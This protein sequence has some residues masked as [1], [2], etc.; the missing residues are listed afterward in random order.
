[1]AQLTF[2]INNGDLPRTVYMPTDNPTVN[3]LVLSIGC[4]A[5]LVLTAG[6]PVDEGSAPSAAGT[7]FYLHLGSLGLSAAE[8][9]SL[10]LSIPG[11]ETALYPDSQVICLAPSVNMTI[12]VGTTVTMR[13]GNFTAASAPSGPA[14][15]VYMKF[16]RASPVSRGALPYTFNDT[17]SIQ[18]PLS[19][20]E[21]FHGV[22]AVSVSNATVVQ[23]I[24]Q[25]PTVAN[26][27]NLIFSPG[28]NPKAVTAGKNTVF[29]VNFV[30]ADD[31]YGYGALTTAAAAFGIKVRGHSGAS[32]WTITDPPKGSANPGWMLQPREGDLILGTGSTVEFSVA[33]IVSSFQPDA[34]LMVVSYSG[35]PGYQDGA[36]WIVLTKER[37]VAVTSLVATPNPAVLEGG[38]ATVNLSWTATPGARLTLMP[39]AVDVTGQSK[40]QALIRQATQFTLSAQGTGTINYAS[41][42]VQVD[43]FARVNAIAATPQ[44]IYHKDFPHDVLIDWAVDT[45]DAVILSNSVNQS[46]QLF[47]SDGT[48]SVTVLAPQMFTIEPKDQSAGLLIRRNEIVS[49]FQLNRKSLTLS[50]VAVDAALSPTA[51]ICIVAQ[52]G[53]SQLLVLDT[54]TNTPYG[55]TVRAGNTPVAVAFSNDGKQLFVANAGDSTLSVFAVS[56]DTASSAYQFSSTAVVALSGVPAAIKVASDGSA[57]FVTSNAAGGAT[58]VLDVV[59]ANGRGPYVVQNSVRFRNTVG[60]LAA[61]PSGAQIFVVST[62]GSA[63]YVVGYDSISKRYSLVRTIGGF[64]S[65]DGP[66]DIE[67][68]GQ[69]FAT[70]LICCK[71]SNSVYCVAK[72]VTSVMGKQRL[73]VGSGPTRL[74]NIQNG[75]YCYVANTGDSTLSLINCFK[76]FGYCSVVETGLA[77]GASPMA[78]AGTS[79]GSLLYVA[80]GASI[81]VWSNA[82]YTVGDSFGAATLCTNVAASPSQV[83]AWHDYNVVFGGKVP[84]PTPGLT[85]YDKES[86]TTALLNRQTQYTN[87]QF[88]PDWT[89]KAALATSV[90]AANLYVLETTRFST[91]ATIELSASA[92]ARAVAVA[93][94]PFGNKAFVLLQDTGAYGLIV[95]DKTTDGSWFQVSATVPLYTQ[96]ASSRPSLAAVSDG[97]SV[98]I[99]DEA[100]AKLYVVLQ[101]ESGDYALDTTTYSFGLSPKEL[102]C[103]P[104]DSQ[105]YAWMNQRN[106]SGFARFDIAAKTLTTVQLPPDAQYQINGMAISPDG[107]RLLV[108][109]SNAGGFRVFSTDGMDCLETVTFP[110]SMLPW[111]VAMAPDGSD[112]YV[113]GALSNNICIASQLQPD[114]DV[115]LQ[116]TAERETLKLENGRYSGLFLRDY[117]GQSPSGGTGSGWTYSP[118]IIPYG[119]SQMADPS[120]LGQQANYNTDYGLNSQIVLDQF[121]NVYFRGI[122]TNNAS[123][124]SRLYA[125]WAVPQICLYPS[126]WSN[127]NFF[128]FSDP[129][130][131]KNWVDITAGPSGSET[132]IG[133]TNVP[134]SWKPLSAYPHY[135]LVAWVDNSDTPTQPDL[136]SF[137]NFSTWDQLGTFIVEHPNIAWRN[138]NDVTSSTEFMNARTLANGPTEGGIVIVGLWLSPSI[139]SLGGTIQFSLLNSD[140]T[141]NYTSPVHTIDT[142]TFSE[143]IDWPKHAPN[144]VLTYSYNLPAGK[145]ITGEEHIT[146]VTSFVPS[147]AH[148]KRLLLRHP[149]DLVAVNT[150]KGYSVIAQVLGTVRQVYRGK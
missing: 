27:F 29:T 25:Y 18:A 49:A 110:S 12:A 115:T 137:S 84:T 85:V 103:A 143:T 86:Q 94:A 136:A 28:Q 87:F 4:D 21:D 146:A 5:P 65:G 149:N 1:M 2:V 51:N 20:K 52:M 46:K 33:N 81:S 118:D 135:C 54:V 48:T 55:N 77:N 82:T 24:P 83:V 39:G 72:D 102:L 116:N 50:A 59:A 117:I 148:L 30:Y 22:L 67:V 8:F 120:V 96:A 79:Q 145:S 15:P 37:H 108:T 64:A 63:I 104:D 70:L 128:A 105:L 99:S 125:F 133:Y 26:S 75:A 106:A 35:V 19:G 62:A 98:F 76:G 147:S 36:F 16:Y 23:T 9:S 53:S 101:G 58:G 130:E 60:Q 42:D 88:W 93:V 57:V 127:S 56:F 71:G 92:T 113:A 129:L 78:L 126:Q 38:Q 68:S 123:Q 112:A 43:I 134:L 45:N 132:A 44:L 7:L 139:V 34:T 47:P 122:N 150:Q 100:S 95:L 131:Q 41:R 121:N 3:Q 11:W 32:H 144:P 142:N 141:I 31:M 89:Q 74:L 119:P 66:A 109:D 138:T 73:T 61:L 17:L 124:K 69:D 80:S 40:Y 140:G 10:K 107:S 91:V 14:S 6:T 13:I 90:G 111:G 97:S 114:V